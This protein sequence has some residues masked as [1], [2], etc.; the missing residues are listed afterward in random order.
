MKYYITDIK[1]IKS[2]LMLIILQGRKVV[3]LNTKIKSILS[4]VNNKFYYYYAR[5][6]C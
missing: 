4:Q 1:L 5:N 2:H 6:I 3:L